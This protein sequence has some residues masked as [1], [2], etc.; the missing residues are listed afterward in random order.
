MECCEKWIVFHLMS[1][2]LHY[3]LN[4]VSVYVAV[5]TCPPSSWRL[6]EWGGIYKTLLLVLSQ[7]T[8]S[9]GEEW[10]K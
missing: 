10:K 9:V 6:L 8:A 1:V 2:T 5:H 7:Y 3:S 4:K